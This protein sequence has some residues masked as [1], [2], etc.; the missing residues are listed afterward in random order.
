MIKNVKSVFYQLKT[1]SSESD[2]KLRMK[3]K[4]SKH[5]S[6]NK[7]LDDEIVSNIIDYKSITKNNKKGDSR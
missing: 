6:K 3:V 5:N 1:L 4:S 7:E 2:Y